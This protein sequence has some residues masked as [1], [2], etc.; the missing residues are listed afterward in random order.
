MWLKSPHLGLVADGEEALVQQGKLHVR[1]HLRHEPPILAQHVPRAAHQ[2]I[3]GG[4]LLQ[5]LKHLRL[6]QR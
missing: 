4:A 3:V 5:R 2:R 6:H 1:G